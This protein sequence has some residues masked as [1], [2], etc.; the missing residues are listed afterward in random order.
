M[1]VDKVGPDMYFQ[2]LFLRSPLGPKVLGMMLDFC[3]FGDVATNEKWQ[4]VQD[5]MKIILD[6]CGLAYADDGEK[7]VRALAGHQGQKA[8]QP[9][10]EAE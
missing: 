7:L 4:H 9:E 3:D 2:D 8:L 6:K 10:P 5:F 1:A